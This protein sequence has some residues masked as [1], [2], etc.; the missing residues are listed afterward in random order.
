MWADTVEEEQMLHLRHTKEQMSYVGIQ[1]EWD[2][3]KKRSLIN[4]LTNEKLNSEAHFHQR[5][6]N[7]LRQ[8]ENYENHNLKKHLQNIAEGS[9]KVI[10]DAVN[11]NDRRIK[12][13]AFKAALKGI[14]HGQMTYDNDPLLPILQEEMN[15]RIQEF[16]GLSSEDESRLLSLSPEQKKLI[17]DQ[18]RKAKH[19][20]LGTLPNI[21]NPG[22]K[23][24]DKYKRYAEMLHNV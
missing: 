5:T 12:D 24:H 20:Y 21:Q 6:L 18:D 22:V 3:I 16:K 10:Q 23:A 14:S 9:L 15:K 11:A 13:Q 8:I 4:Y 1:Q 17:Q 19:D 2:F 7:M